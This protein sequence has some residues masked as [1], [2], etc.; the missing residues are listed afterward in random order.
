MRTLYCLAASLAFA[1]ALPA[2][3]EVGDDD[4]LPAITAYIH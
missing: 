3:A 1:M 2:A 4:K